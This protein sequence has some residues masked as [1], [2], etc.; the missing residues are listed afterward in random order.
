MKM[1]ITI[2]L[3]VLVSVAKCEWTCESC[4]AVVNTLAKYMTSEESIQSQVEILVPEIRPMIPDGADNCEEILPGFWTRLALFMGPKY[5]D[6]QEDFMC[7]VTGLCGDP[8]TRLLTLHC[9]QVIAFCIYYFQ[10]FFV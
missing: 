4:K 2:V 10:V 6:P 7:G 9:N 8:E 1:K 3:A 5:Y